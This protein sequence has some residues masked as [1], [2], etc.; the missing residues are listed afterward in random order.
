MARGVRSNAVKMD[1]SKRTLAP[2]LLDWWAEASNDLSPEEVRDAF[3]RGEILDAFDPVFQRALGADFNWSAMELL[4]DVTCT[5]GG[6]EGNDVNGLFPPLL[7]VLGCLIQVKKSEKAEVNKKLRHRARRERSFKIQNDQVLK[8]GQQLKVTTTF[9]PKLQAL[10]DLRGRKVKRDAVQDI[11]LEPVAKLSRRVP[12]PVLLSDVQLVDLLAN[13]DSDCEITHTKEKSSGEPTQTEKFDLL[14]LKRVNTAGLGNCCP[15]SV[16]QGFGNPPTQDISDSFREIAATELYM[17]SAWREQFDI[18]SLEAWKDYISQVVRRDGIWVGDAF[19]KA[20]AVSMDRPI[21][22]IGSG[23]SFCRV[24]TEETT[25]LVYGHMPW[26]A[27]RAWYESYP[28]CR[29]PVCIA[30]NGSAAVMG[31]HYDALKVI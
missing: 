3:Q 13:S 22:S 1:F 25:G 7:L 31:D 2:L 27:F 14:G 30:Y 9:P 20:I 24:Y 10:K 19:C 17:H 16:A 15:L 23:R 6:M 4:R 28:V 26:V 11:S 5:V 29:R 21:V 8:S 18:C 12:V